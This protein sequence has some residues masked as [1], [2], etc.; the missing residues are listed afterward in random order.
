MVSR[1]LQKA[2]PLSMSIFLVNITVLLR[3][4]AQLLSA[5]QDECHA[6]GVTAPRTLEYAI[7]LSRQWVVSLEDWLFGEMKTLS[8]TQ[9]ARVPDQTECSHKLQH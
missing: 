6:R 1:A 7:S 8:G 4:I 5:L 3:S 9:A 2:P